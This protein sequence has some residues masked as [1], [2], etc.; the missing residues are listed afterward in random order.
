M[1]G[2]VDK[3]MVFPLVIL[4]NVGV[5]VVGGGFIYRGVVT[6]NVNNSGSMSE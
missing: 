2:K 6:V 4:G 3:G 5:V 1:L